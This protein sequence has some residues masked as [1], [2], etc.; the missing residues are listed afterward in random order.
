MTLIKI[1]MDWLGALMHKLFIGALLFVAMYAFQQAIIHANNIDY[2]F[3][4]TT[5]A[6]G[7]FCTAYMVHELVFNDD[8]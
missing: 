5:V 7:L 4:L 6:Y 8:E 3:M 1:K 2:S